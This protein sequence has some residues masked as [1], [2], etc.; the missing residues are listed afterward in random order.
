M[1]GV[2]D[3]F[4]RRAAP[5]GLIGRVGSAVYL[6]SILRTMFWR[7]YGQN[8]LLLLQ[9][10]LYFGKSILEYD[11]MWVHHKYVHNCVWVS[12]R[13]CDVHDYFKFCSFLNFNCLQVLCVLLVFRLRLVCA[14]LVVLPTKANCRLFDFQSAKK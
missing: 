1:K 3:E 12:S 8:L 5:D 2:L 13:L 10:S 11:V 6:D 9:V 7:P 4:F 14:V